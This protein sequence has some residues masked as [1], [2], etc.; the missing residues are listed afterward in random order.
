MAMASCVPA[1]S[2]ASSPT[3]P[4]KPGRPSKADEREPLVVTIQDVLLTTWDDLKQCNEVLFS[5]RV[6]NRLLHEWHRKVSKG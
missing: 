5:F 4:R 3:V 6:P 2:S 1:E